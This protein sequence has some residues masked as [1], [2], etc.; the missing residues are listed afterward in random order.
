MARCGSGRARGFETAARS[1]GTEPFRPGT[2]P[3]GQAGPSWAAGLQPCPQVAPPA[4]IC[5]WDRVRAA[6][7]PCSP[8]PPPPPRH[9]ARS[10]SCPHT[11]PRAW[12]LP[13]PSRPAPGDGLPRGT[14]VGGAGRV[15][16]TAPSQRGLR[17]LAGAGSPQQPQPDAG[18]GS[19]HP[20]AP[21]QPPRREPAVAGARPR[22][23][24]EP[25]DT[26][27][28]QKQPLGITRSPSATRPLP[29]PGQDET[30]PASPC[31]GTVGAAP[32]RAQEGPAGAAWLPQG[33]PRC[34]APAR[35]LSPS[36]RLR[37]CAG[38]ST[39]SWARRRPPPPHGAPRS[40]GARDKGGGASC[41]PRSKAAGGAPVLP[42][43]PRLRAA[44]GTGQLRGRSGSQG[45]APARRPSSGNHRGAPGAGRG[46]GRL[47]APRCRG[48]SRGVCGGPRQEPAAGGSAALGSQAGL[49]GGSTG[50]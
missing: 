21:R 17:S 31:T 10:Q 8:P 26:K 39:S 38:D 37:G 5:A 44:G 18:P 49:L 47:R 27:R 15:P 3:A 13:G 34:P 43:P 1:R 19:P 16:G 50:L 35:P 22:R 30:G 32:S 25:G 42:L 4:W 7:V 20:R 33:C 6:P 12:G 29:A 23:A 9:H 14:G 45:R 24:D 40:R 2:A 46:R 11:K 28:G 48:R 41:R 36:V